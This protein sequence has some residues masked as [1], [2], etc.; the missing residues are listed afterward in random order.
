MAFLEMKVRIGSDFYIT[1]L[2]AKEAGNC[3]GEAVV[4]RLLRYVLQNVILA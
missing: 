3:G 4:S 1:I 2:Y